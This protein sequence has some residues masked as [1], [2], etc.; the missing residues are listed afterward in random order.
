MDEREGLVS[1]ANEMWEDFG[2]AVEIPSIA[3]LLRRQASYYA[4]RATEF[5]AWAS[6][7]EAMAAKLL[8]AAEAHRRSAEDARILAET[9]STIAEQHAVASGPS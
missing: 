4:S 6:N 1:G 9:A 7:C 3:L 2:R 8:D 5:V